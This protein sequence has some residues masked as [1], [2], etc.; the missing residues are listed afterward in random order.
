MATLGMDRFTKRAKNFIEHD[1][2]SFKEM[3]ALGL[4]AIKLILRNTRLGYGVDNAGNK[5]KLKK[6]AD[7]Y[8]V[9]RKKFGFLDSTTKPSKS[10]LT[11]TGQL[12]RS[13]KVLTTKRLS[14]VVGPAGYRKRLGKQKPM[15]NDF[16]ANILQKKDAGR[17]YRFLDISN[18][19]EKKLMRFYRRRFGD[20][21]KLRL[22]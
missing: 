22:Q 9:F 3:K 17:S 20:L 6:H 5:F 16:L 21:V 10:N 11:L 2:V 13:I 1:A 8:K 12:L 19:D 18:V 14:V 4:E 7:S 15:A